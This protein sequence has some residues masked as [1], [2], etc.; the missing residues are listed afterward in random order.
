MSAVLSVFLAT[1]AFAAA[2]KELALP[3]GRG[4]R[5][6]IQSRDVKRASLQVVGRGIEGIDAKAAIDGAGR[7]L[8]WK[9]IR[10]KTDAGGNL[11]VFYRQY[12]TDGNITAEVYGSE[13]GAHYTPDGRLYSVSGAQARQ[14]NVANGVSLDRQ[15]AIEAAA[16]RMLA[17]ETRVR[18]LDE[19]HAEQRD[20]ALNAAKL[21]LMERDGVY[22]YTYLTYASD[23]SDNGLQIAIDAD[24]E[25]IVA[26]TETNMGGNCLPTGSMVTVNA[27]GTPVRSGVSNRSIKAHPATD[28][29][30]PYT[31]EGYWHSVPYKTVYQQITGTG[32]WMCANM[33]DSWTIFPLQTENSVVVYKD[34]VDGSITWHGSAA[35]DAIYHSD[36]TMTYLKFIHGR[37]GWDDAYGPVKIIIDSTTPSRDQAQFNANVTATSPN[38]AVMMGLPGR[39][40]QGA[41]SLDWVAHE[42]GHGVIN[43]SANF[44]YSG[45]G[46]ELH[47]GFADVI[48]HATERYYHAT[49]SGVETDDWLMHEDAASSGYARGAVDDNGGHNW[50]GP[51]TYNGQN[52]YT[53]ND[54]LH[55]NDTPTTNTNAH[56]GA[57]KLAVVLRLLTEGGT[58]PVCARL[59]T[60]SGCSTSVTGQGENKAARIMVTALESTLPSNSTWSTLADDVAQAAFNLYNACGSNPLSNASA[61][62]TAVFNAF[63]AI[64]HP[65]SGVLNTCP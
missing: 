51:T 13:V 10:R 30:S 18:R 21:V 41:A 25:Q 24:T 60:L 42:W 11:N 23:L 27:T 58:N 43:T 19:M 50:T 53:F 49:G 16:Y 40:Y 46:A 44:P 65:G 8:L 33:S 20:R 34:R 4:E 54:L 57:N 47:E 17:R 36:K 56:S 31:H 48:G 3:E 37:D 5:I 26:I 63:T 64:G 32:T 9:E 39:M 61:E 55:A 1:G 45:V 12:L 38:N 6:R 2:S 29:P 15:A 14:V 28:R 62:Q 7:E 59:S 35:G 52:Y 22:H